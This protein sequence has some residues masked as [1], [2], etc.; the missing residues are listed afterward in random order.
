MA[1]T[2]LR[3]AGRAGA[4][5]PGAGQ[6]ARFRAHP[7]CVPVHR[8]ARRRQDDHR[9]HP[10]EV[11]ELREGRRLQAL[12][13]VQH[14][15]RGRRGALRRPDRSRRRVAHQGGRHARAAGERPVPADARPLQ[16][17]PHRRSAHA[18]EPLVQRA[19]EDAR[20]AAAA[21][22]VPAGDDRSAEAAGHR[23]VALPAVQPEAAARRADRRAPAADPA[24]RGRGLR[25]RGGGAAVARGRRQPARRPV[26]ARPDARVRR[27]ARHRGRRARHARHRGPPAGRARGRAPR[28]ARRAR[29]DRRDRRDRRVRAGLRAAA[30]RDRGAAAEGRAAPG[31]A[32]PSRGRDV[33]HRAARGACRDDACGG[34]AAGDSR[35]R[36]SAAATWNWRRTRAPASR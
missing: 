14:L 33:F 36:S 23:A 32:G 10:R 28:R 12:R 8:H 6:C 30:R 25:A 34:P 13:R 2:Q 29:A 4:R 17:V 21:R 16:G 9:A 22:Q 18:V 15:P 5:A 7:P 31:R 24:G 20:G 11:A 3:G 35:S 27:R 19:A 26:A 1:A